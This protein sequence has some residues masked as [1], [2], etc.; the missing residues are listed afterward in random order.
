M[1]EVELIGVPDKQAYTVVTADSKTKAYRRVD[2]R[3][4][5][6]AL[7]GEDVIND[8]VK[9]EQRYT[10]SVPVVASAAIKSAPG[11]LHALIFRATMP[12][13][14]LERSMC[15]T[16]PPLREIRFLAGRSPRQPLFRLASL[17][18]CHFQRACMWPS[19]LR[20][21]SMSLR[22]TDESRS[23]LYRSGALISL[24]GGRQQRHAGHW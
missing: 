18:T 1:A 22:V 7:A 12:R 16:I 6:V 10:Y 21:M 4:I 23:K 24:A 5:L 13:R 8:V 11:F 17:W 9:V 20:R 15:T 3:D 14:R 19:R 2:I